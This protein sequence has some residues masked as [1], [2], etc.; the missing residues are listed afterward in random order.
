MDKIIWKLPAYYTDLYCSSLILD[1][2]PSMD[3]DDVR[4]GNESV[5]KKYGVFK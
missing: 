5:H 3:N 2:L 4:R 1:D